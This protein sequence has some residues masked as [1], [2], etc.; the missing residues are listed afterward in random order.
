MPS[1]GINNALFAL[2]S[3]HIKSLVDKLIIF[4]YKLKKI[5]VNSF[6]FKKK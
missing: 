1:K 2:G 4:G 5:P 6:N 3:M